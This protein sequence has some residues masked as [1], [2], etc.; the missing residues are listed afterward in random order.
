MLLY[1]LD[2]RKKKTHWGGVA[3]CF[4]GEVDQAHLQRLFAC[5]LV[6]Q[7]PQKQ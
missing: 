5:T 3:E 4:G 6:L 7:C 1:I 2:L